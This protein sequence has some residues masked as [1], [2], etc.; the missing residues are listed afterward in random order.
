MKR[1]YKSAAAAAGAGGFAVL[2]D[3][4][5]MRTPGK[6]PLA[7]PSRALAAGDRGGMAGAGRRGRPR[8]AAADAACQH[9]DRSRRAAARRDRGRHRQICRH[10]SA[11][12][13]RG[14]SA[15]R[16]SR[17]R[18]RAWQPLLDW[19][20][21]RYD[22]PLAVTAGVMPRAQPPASL[23]AL[24]RRDRGLRRDGARRAPSR[25]DRVRLARAGA[26]ARR[27]P[28]RRRNRPSPCRSSTRA[29][30][31]S[32]GA[33]MRSRRAGAPRSARISSRRRAF[34]RCCAR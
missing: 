26:G 34:S 10:R 9:R 12:L 5:P 7:V 27:G 15:R 3:G 1:F 20:A 16:W 2:L 6:Q 24:G 29:S 32:T 22:A 18:T 14:A 21:L 19:V 28:H 30:R 17:A 8:L 25:D 31:S 4:K 33:R 13:P 11:V 23:A